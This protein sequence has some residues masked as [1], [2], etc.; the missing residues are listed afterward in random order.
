MI[1]F[2]VD[3]YSATSFFVLSTYFL[4][5]NFSFTK[6]EKERN[7][8]LAE[9]EIILQELIVLEEIKKIKNEISNLKTC[10]DETV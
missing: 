8:L 3:F 9:K 5:K 7:R 6:S 4:W 2:L 10:F 1:K